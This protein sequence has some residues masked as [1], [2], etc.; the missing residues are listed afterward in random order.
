MAVWTVA[1]SRSVALTKSDMAFQVCSRVAAIEVGRPNSD[2]TRSNVEAPSARVAQTKMTG[3]VGD[4]MGRCGPQGTRGWSGPLGVRCG[5]P[6]T[7]GCGCKGVEGGRL[8]Y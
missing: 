8:I 1:V 2:C 5:P 3:G 4:G 6:G 7:K